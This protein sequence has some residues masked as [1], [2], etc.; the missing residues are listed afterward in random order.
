[1]LQLQHYYCS[2]FLEK[3]IK[4]LEPMTI[5]DERTKEY[6]DDSFMFQNLQRWL[7]Q[8]MPMEE[9]QKKEPVRNQPVR[10]LLDWFA[11]VKG[12]R[13]EAVRQLKKRFLYLDYE[14]QIKV[15]D[16]F[17]EGSKSYR[18]WCYDTLTKWREPR[19][20]DRLIALWQEH[21][22]RQCAWTIVSQLP[23]EKVLLVADSIVNCIYK[24]YLD[25]PWSHIDIPVGLYYTMC[26]K[27]AGCDGFKLNLDL[28]RFNCMADLYIA[29]LNQVGIKED[30]DICYTI[31]HN[32][33]IEE[34]VDHKENIPTEDVNGNRIYTVC[35]NRTIRVLREIL[36]MGH[37]ELVHDILRW[38]I[39]NMYSFLSAIKGWSNEAKL[40]RELEYFIEF[41]LNNLPHSIADL[42]GVVEKKFTK[43]QER[44]INNKAVKSFVES[45]DLVIQ[46]V[47]LIDEASF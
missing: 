6:I 16:L 3:K 32:C 35:Y 43:P 1:M 27:L 26:K 8:E 37:E 34:L 28:L 2:L 24:E 47:P 19:Y 38:D 15:M 9:R 7:L 11:K 42:R 25:F 46:D 22:E 5:S 20:D 4:P 29:L 41:T 36:R 21:K 31:V 17:I 39:N 33:I 23:A 44:I 13:V 12:K 18:M 45:L 14:D 30:V 10:V 40:E